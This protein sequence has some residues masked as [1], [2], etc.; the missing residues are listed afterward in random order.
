MALKEISLSSL[1]DT[2][3]ETES[4]FA[5]FFRPMLGYD[6]VL[7]LY[8]GINDDVEQLLVEVEDETGFEFPG[9]MISFYMCTNGGVFGDL[10][11]YSIDEDK[12]IENN[13]HTI[14]VTNKTLKESIGLDNSSILIGEY[15]NSD[16]YVTCTLNSDNEYTY[17]IWDSIKKTVAMQF[18]YLIQ[19]IALE[20]S[21]AT[22][23]EGF[24][25]IVNGEID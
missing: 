23:Y 3:D 14:N 11:L 2:L 6:A 19:I 5:D 10:K 15:L 1:I 8:E 21:Y 22:D 18:E 16:M 9:D 4:E 12:T 25:K 20:I 7:T 24:T 17:Q 13:I